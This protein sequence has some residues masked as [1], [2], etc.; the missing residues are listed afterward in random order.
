MVTDTNQNYKKG[1]IPS[2]KKIFR[3]VNSVKAFQLETNSS[4]G[5]GSE[6][7]TF[8][9]TKPLSQSSQ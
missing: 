4:T 6:I 5:G 2:S 3:H 7:I 1:P 8:S 9:I